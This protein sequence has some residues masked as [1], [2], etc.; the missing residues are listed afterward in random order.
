MHSHDERGGSWTMWVMMI[1][2]V[3]LL[4]LLVLFGLGGKA[5]GAPTWIVLGGVALMVVA[6]FFMMGQSHKHSDEEQST[7]DEE[8]ETKDS[9]DHSGSSCCHEH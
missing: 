7:T 2:C 8:N 1:G 9:K 5:L 4:L 6:H 3:A